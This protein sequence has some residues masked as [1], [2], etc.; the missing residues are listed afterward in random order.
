[1]CATLTLS[2]GVISIAFDSAPIRREPT[3]SSRRP[4]RSNVQLSDGRVHAL[5]GGRHNFNPYLIVSHAIDAIS[6][7]AW[8]ARTA[9]SLP[10]TATLFT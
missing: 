2:A 7:K 4:G 1:M 8:P 3:P 6:P 5:R 9:G 10:L